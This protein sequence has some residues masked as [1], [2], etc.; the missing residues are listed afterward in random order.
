MLQ[1]DGTFKCLMTDGA[2]WG[3]HE[4]LLENVH[5]PNACK[6]EPCTIHNPLDDHM[7]DWPLLWRADKK[8]FERTCEHGIGHPDAADAAFLKRVG[9]DWTS[10]HGCC[11]CCRPEASEP[12]LASEPGVWAENAYPS[13]VLTPVDLGN[14]VDWDALKPTFELGERV[15][16]Y[17]Y[18]WTIESIREGDGVAVLKR[19][20]GDFSGDVPTESIVALDRLQKLPPKPVEK[21]LKDELA[22]NA[23]QFGYICEIGFA[24]SKEQAFNIF[25]KYFD[26]KGDAIR[27]YML[28]CI[29][30]D[31]GSCSVGDLRRIIFGDDK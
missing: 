16:H 18:E 11:G 28:N 9:R 5:S 14:H 8:I 1:E 24:L 26:S 12:F 23:Q 31:G 30:H 27:D 6:G 13:K 17:L 4:G 22:E 15:V 2:G 29:D 3:R 21:T 7:K 20:T 25:T 10:T 19:E